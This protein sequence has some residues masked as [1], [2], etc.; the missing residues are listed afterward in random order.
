MHTDNKHTGID[1]FGMII[2]YIWKESHNSGYFENLNN[3]FS[4]I[5]NKIDN[6]IIL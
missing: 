6:Q 5:I 2:Q 4:K 1:N 3:K